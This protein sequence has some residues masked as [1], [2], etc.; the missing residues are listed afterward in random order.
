MIS[1]RIGSSSSI[2]IT[3]IIVVVDKIP[4]V[5]VIINNMVKV[6]DITII[7]I[8]ITMASIIF[9]TSIQK[10]VRFDLGDMRS[11]LW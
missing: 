5:I 11:R 4:I 2:F 3:G 8:S 6:N 1:D 10:W 9:M 7:R